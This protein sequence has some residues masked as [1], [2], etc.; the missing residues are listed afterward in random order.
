MDLLQVLRRHRRPVSG[1]E[2]AVE[3]GTSLRTLYR[4]IAALQG[5]GADIEG[6]PGVGYVLR[7][8]FFLPP[9]MLSQ[10][11]IEALMLGMRWVSAFADRPLAAASTDALSK[12]EAVLPKTSRHGAGAVPLRVGP[13]I[14]KASADEDLTDLR[15]AIRHERKLAITYRDRDGRESERVIWPFAIGYFTDGRILVGWCENR[16]AYRHFRTDRLI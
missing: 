1:R 11:E 6:E 15:D 14:S 12:I 4:D 9:L 2:L 7:P 16:G 10:A 13:P 3:M 5:M 8:G